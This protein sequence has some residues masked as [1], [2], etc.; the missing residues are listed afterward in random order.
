M[1]STFPFKIELLQNFW[2]MAT[3]AVNLL[4]QFQQIGMLANDIFSDILSVINTQQHKMKRVKSR[5]EKL[6]DRTS[7]AEL[8]LISSAPSTFYDHPHPQD[9]SEEYTPYRYTSYESYKTGRRIDNFFSE[10]TTKPYIQ[11]WRNNQHIQTAIN[12]PVKYKDHT[13]YRSYSH[14][15]KMGWEIQHRF[16]QELSESITKNKSNSDRIN[17]KFKYRNPQRYKTEA[18]LQES[19]AYDGFHGDYILCYDAST[20]KHIK[21]KVPKARQMTQISRSTSKHL[22]QSTTESASSESIPTPPPPPLLPLSYPQML[23]PPNPVTQ[24]PP[25]P[26]PPPHPMTAARPPPNPI[27]RRQQLLQLLRNNTSRPHSPVTMPRPPPMPPVPPQVPVD[28]RRIRYFITRGP[29]PIQ[30]PRHPMLAPSSGFLSQWRVKLNRNKRVSRYDGNCWH[31]KTSSCEYKTCVIKRLI[32]HK[33]YYSYKIKDRR[34]FRKKLKKRGVVLSLEQQLMK[35][36]LLIYGY[37]I[38]DGINEFGLSIPWDVIPLIV[39]YYGD[40]YKE[41][42][43]GFDWNEWFTEYMDEGEICPS[44]EVMNQLIYPQGYF[45]KMDTILL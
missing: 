35:I 14:T 29:P 40:E 9:L 10:D 21:F 22:P 28:N 44:D 31:S 43:E 16:D 26:R 37:C 12:T 13:F 17:Y 11:R 27:E 33:E 3:A 38:N 34:R 15:L 41:N 24:P 1:V 2:A 32:K 36:D 18:Q 5:I 30:R 39:M 7:V 8:N 19:S 4:Q 45:G 42:W 6:E 20:H 23:P 25:F